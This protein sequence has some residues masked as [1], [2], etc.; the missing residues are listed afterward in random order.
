[1][2]ISVPWR[3]MYISSW[4][5]IFGAISVVG[6]WR[7]EV[8]CFSWS[9][10]LTFRLLSSQLPY[11]PGHNKKKCET[12]QNRFIVVTV[13]SVWIVTLEV[14]LRISYTTPVIM[15][16]VH[17]KFKSNNEFKTLTFDGVNISVADLRK[18]IVQKSKMGKLMDDFHL[19]ITNPQTGEGKKV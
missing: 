19:Q 7:I 3:Y 2:L 13:T 5:N 14:V 18:E 10:T 17:Y 15:S 16:S 4:E 8:C 9:L 6:Q 12:R 11:V 1:M